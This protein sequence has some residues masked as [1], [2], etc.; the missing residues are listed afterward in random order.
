MNRWLIFPLIVMFVSGVTSCSDDS[1]CPCHDLRFKTSL[2]RDIDFIN[3]TYF[4]LDYPEWDVFFHPLEDWIEVFESVE[5]WEV[6]AD[7]TLAVWYGR[8]WVD[9]MG[10]GMGIREALARLEA[11][12]PPFPSQDHQYRLLREG[13]DYWLIRDPVVDAV[14]GVE[15]AEPRADSRA[16]GVRYVNE[17]EDSIGNFG[18]FADTLAL[19][20]VKPQWARPDDEFYY[21]WPYVM[22]NIY[23]LG[24]TNIRSDAFDLQ[25]IDDVGGGPVPVGA[26]VPWVRVF[27]LDQTGEGGV[28]PPDGFVDLDLIDFQRGILT[29]PSLTPFAPSDELVEMYT[30]GLFSFA[31]NPLYANIRQPEIYTRL[32]TVP[33]NYSHFTIR[34][35]A[36]TYE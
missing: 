33:Q 30:D 25:I 29:F 34:L 19:E 32:L 35:Q 9:T 28:G 36:A 14:I 7:P 17:L 27:G 18:D 26:G 6:A 20:L 13:E 31:D 22:R 21:T 15:F 3:N 4:F 5:P 10:R 2:I 24:M 16:V 8:A 23:D 12:L 11:G 1:Q